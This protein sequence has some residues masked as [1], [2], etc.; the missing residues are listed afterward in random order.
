VRAA[1][2]PVQLEYNDRGD[3]ITVSAWQLLQWKHALRLEAKG[4]TMSRG[5]KVSTH[6]RRLMNLKRNTPVSYLSEWVEGALDAVNTAMGVE[7]G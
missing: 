3:T 1:V 7:N 4:M 2:V 5:R 6:L